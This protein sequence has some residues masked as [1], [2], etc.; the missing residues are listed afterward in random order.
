MKI[1]TTITKLFLLSA[2][3]I[4]L[5]ACGPKTFGQQGDVAM[6]DPMSGAHLQ[7]SLT[8][9]DYLRLAE[10][11]TNKML[12]TPFVQSWGSKRPKLI[13]GDLVN[14]TDDESIR[15]RD[16]HDRI[17]E[18]IF[19]SGLVRVVDTS[20][21]SFDYIIKSEM[22]STRQYGRNNQEMVIFTLQLKMFK[23]DGELVLQQSDDLA[24]AK[25]ER[26]MF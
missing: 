6:V 22:T 4:S 18:V 3:L 2:L 5:S 24:L 14:N 16:I 26:R 12:A 1:L 13:V 7:T 15:M 8:M 20:A 19:N 10:T 23:L 17:Q 21:T 9:A 25:A 11:V